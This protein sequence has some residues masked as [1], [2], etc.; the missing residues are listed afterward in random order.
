MNKI[1]TH[2]RG[3][4]VGLPLQVVVVV[5]L[6]AGCGAGGTITVEDAWARAAGARDITGAFFTLDNGGEDDVLL[7]ADSDVAEAVE[8]HQTVMEGD[9]MS[10][11]MQESV[12]VPTGELAFQPGSLHVML[13]GLTRD[14]NAG[15][16]FALTLNFE[17]AGVVVVSVEVLAP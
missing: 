6:L 12:A 10:M 7:S 15:D 8:I 13:I 11:V 16:E 5:L 9:I 1:M 17:Q 3:R 2:I 4:H 14:L